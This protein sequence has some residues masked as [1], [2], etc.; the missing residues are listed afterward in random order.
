M[1]VE[2]DMKMTVA[3]ASVSNKHANALVCSHHLSA[4]DRGV[5]VVV[6]GGGGVCILTV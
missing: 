3:G 2:L 1:D 6:V 5:V 4:P